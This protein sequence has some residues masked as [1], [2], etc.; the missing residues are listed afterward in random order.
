MLFFPTF[1]SVAN[2][3]EKSRAAHATSEIVEQPLH[4]LQKTPHHENGNVKQILT[5]RAFFFYSDPCFTD[6]DDAGSLAIKFD[7]HLEGLV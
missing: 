2:L 6:W 3:K 1:N 5:F 4:H 7:S